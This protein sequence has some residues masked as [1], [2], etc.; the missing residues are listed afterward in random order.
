MY[1]CDK[2]EVNE[3]HYIVK[4]A[5]SELSFYD[6]LC[7]RCCGLWL[8]SKGDVVGALKFGVGA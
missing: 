2:C 8:L 4:G 1:M 7:A 6:A 3:G 5:V